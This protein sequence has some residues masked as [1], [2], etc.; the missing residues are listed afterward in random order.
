LYIEVPGDPAP[1]IGFP[2]LKNHPKSLTVNRGGSA[3]FV[4]ELEAGASD[5]INATWMK[6]GKEL[7]EQPMKIKLSCN[8]TLVSLNISDS[9]PGDAGQYACIVSNNKGEVKAAFSLNVH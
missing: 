1:P 3:A 6:D 2:K 7:K 4:A 5:P 9:G 8:K